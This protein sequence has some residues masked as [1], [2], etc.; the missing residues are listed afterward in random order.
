[1]TV[2][3]ES[4]WANAPEQLI[5]IASIHQPSTAIFE[6]FDKLLL[7][8]AGKT[9]YFGPARDT[10]SY[11]DS[12]GCPMPLQ[13]NPAEFILDL[14]SSDFAVN[15]RRVADVKLEDI[16][17]AWSN[18]SEAQVVDS[19]I[20]RLSGS[21]EKV[22]AERLTSENFSGPNPLHVIFS[23]L[24]RSWTKSRRDVV[25]YGIRIIMYLGELLF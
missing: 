8:S 2:E 19:E 1:M 11:F 23:L 6:L 12:I 18:S 17:T 22:G 16:H 10:K 15:R 5:I 21:E 3:E 25:A 7:L 14:V 4:W 13:I 20:R 9:C 24:H